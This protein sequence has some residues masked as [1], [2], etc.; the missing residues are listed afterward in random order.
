MNRDTTPADRRTAARAM[1]RRIEVIDLI[2]AAGNGHM[3]GSL[4]CL[5]ILTVLYERVLRVSPS[6]TRDPGRDRFILS[7]GHA[8]EALYVVLAEFGFIPRSDLNS[9]LRFGT[10]FVGHATRSIPGI[11]QSTGA[12]GHGLSLGVGIAIAGRS[13]ALDYRTYVLLGDGELAEGSVWEA[14]MSASHYALGNLVA[15]VDRN[16]LQI[17]GTTKEI[18]DT[19]PLADKFRSFGWD[20]REVDGH[21]VTQLASVL[22]RSEPAGARPLAVL[23]NTVKGK[24]VSYMEDNIAWHHKVPTPEEYAIALAE[25]SGEIAALE[26]L[27]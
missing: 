2:R 17:A 3:A 26:R 21:D 8:V 10:K 18:L 20:V 14:A 22:D 11:E 23:A 16:R 25:L 4:S 1:Q 6:T 24:G 15:I 12:L 19:E 13:D 7:K 9:Y 5:D 27:S